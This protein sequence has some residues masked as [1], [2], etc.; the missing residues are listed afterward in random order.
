MG[1]D[2]TGSVEIDL[3]S[4]SGNCGEGEFIYQ[5]AVQNQM[6]CENA[7]ML[8]CVS[9]LRFQKVRRELLGEDERWSVLGQSMVPKTLLTVPNPLL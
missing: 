6:L 7:T 5:K 4:D 8:L 1:G 3:V 9:N 2:H